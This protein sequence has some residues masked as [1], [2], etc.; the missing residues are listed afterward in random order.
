MASFTSPLQFYVK[1][2]MTATE[3]AQIGT[4]LTTTTGN[5]VQGRVNV[6][7]A[8]AAVLASASMMPS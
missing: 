6:N 4:N 7:P 2:Q 8:S 1:S 3:F 5:Y